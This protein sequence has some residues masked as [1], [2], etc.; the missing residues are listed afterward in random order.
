MVRRDFGRSAGARG[1]LLRQPHFAAVVV[2]LL[3][4]AGFLVRDGVRCN[5]GFDVVACLDVGFDAG[6][7]GGGQGAGHG[8]CCW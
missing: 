8:C 7:H 4:R 3:H 1:F 2:E 5:D 6:A